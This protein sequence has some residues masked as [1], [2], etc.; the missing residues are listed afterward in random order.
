MEGASDTEKLGVDLK[1][2]EIKDANS[3]LPEPRGGTTEFKVYKRRWAI[4]ALYLC[5]NTIGAFQ[6]IQYAIIA[7][8][9]VDYYNVPSQA[10]NWTSVIFMVAF[11]I[12]IIPATWFYNKFGLRLALLLAMGGTLLGTWIKVFSV[13]PDLFWV[14]FLGQ[15]IVALSQTYVLSIPVP[16]AA[17]WFGPSE[18][19]TACSIGLIGA[20]IGGALGFFIPVALVPDNGDIAAIETGLRYLFYGSAI[21]SS[22]VFVLQLM[23]LQSE[24]PTPPSLAQASRGTNNESV[25]DYV[26]SLWKLFKNVHFVLIFLAYSINVAVYSAITTFLNQMI[27]PIYPDAQNDAGN[28]GV[29]ITICGIIGSVLVGFLLDQTRRY[30]EM[31]IIV[32]ALSAV[33]M[34]CYTFVLRSGNISYVYACAAFFGVTIF[35]YLPAAFEFAA[36]LTYPEPEASAAGLMTFGCQFLSAIYTLAYGWV[37]TPYGDLASNLFMSC[38]LIVGTVLTLFVKSDLRRQHADAHEN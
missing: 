27:I 34:L 3:S 30:K 19:S 21:I 2:D 16:L 31:N 36:E 14:T 13:H 22:I 12:A 32:Y 20:Q 23:F 17:T 9:I 5:Y 28:I 26:K 35:G 11:V 4:L 18:V 7:D 29:L 38:S 25:L 15:T 37:F 24:P 33:A 1:E 10:V 6:W 8:V